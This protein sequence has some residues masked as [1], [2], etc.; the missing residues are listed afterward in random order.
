MNLLRCYN[1]SWLG[2]TEEAI[3]VVP[4]SDTIDGKVFHDTTQQE[5]CPGCDDTN[6]TFH[7]LGSLM[8]AI[9]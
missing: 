2:S 9:D 5:G 8:P 6:A 1:C 7:I 3:V 4:Y